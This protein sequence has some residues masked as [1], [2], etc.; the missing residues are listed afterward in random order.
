[1]SELTPLTLA[2]L[3]KL[4]LGR[5][6][7]AFDRLLKQAISDCVDRP[8]DDRARKVTLQIDLVPVKQVHDNTISCEGAKGA[9]KAK[10]ALPNYETQTLDF[11]VK[12]SGHAYFAE[13]SPANHQQATLFAGESD[14]D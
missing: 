10:L 12:Q 6:G 2:T 1:M 9:V 4:D 13:E 7:M 3:K 11:G 14:A 8:G 5:V